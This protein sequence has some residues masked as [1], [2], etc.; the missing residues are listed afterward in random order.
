MF[1]KQTESKEENIGLLQTL[2][3]KMTNEYERLKTENDSKSAEQTQSSNLLGHYYSDVFNKSS[4]T[5]GL[6]DLEKEPASEKAH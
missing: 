2:M 1:K 5:R 3:G 4:G 6:I